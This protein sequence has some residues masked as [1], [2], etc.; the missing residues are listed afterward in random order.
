MMKST[1]WDYYSLIRSR[2]LNHTSVECFCKNGDKIAS[3]K[4]RVSTSPKECYLQLKP[5]WSGL[6]IEPSQPQ[7]LE[8]CKGSFAS[9]K[10]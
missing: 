5:F 4:R 9:L 7:R 2:M 1:L 10:Q 8:Q 3:L 6:G